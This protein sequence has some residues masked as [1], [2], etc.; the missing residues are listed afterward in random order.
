MVCWGLLTAG[1]SVRRPR[2]LTTGIC[3]NLRCDSVSSVFRNPRK[4]D[5]M[6]YKADLG[7]QLGSVG[8][9]VRC[10]ADID[11][12]VLDLQSALINCFHDNCQLRQRKGRTATRWWSADLGRKR[13]QVRKLFNTCKRS[14]VWE[15]Y[16]R[17]LTDY[18]LAIKK[19]KQ[20]S[21]R[22]FAQE[23]D[24]LPA[25]ARL[26]RMLSSSPIGLLGTLRTTSGNFTAGTGDSLKLLLETHFPDCVFEDDSM[27]RPGN[28]GG[29]SW[30]RADSGSWALSRQIVTVSKIRWAINKFSPY[31]SPGGGWSVPGPA[32]AGT[33]DSP[34]PPL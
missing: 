2:C 7:C 28:C 5:W 10:F 6:A 22:R 21:W 24:S 14:R 29:S 30:P 4:T 25:A 9:R 34:A 31:K 3:F 18:S 1:T 17:A 27:A 23:V 32:A 8:R 15:P 13:A 12:S 11:Q 16:H 19:A 20:D 26:Q 33:G